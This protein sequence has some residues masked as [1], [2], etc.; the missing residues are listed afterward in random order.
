MSEQPLGAMTDKS[1]Q[2]SIAN[3]VEQ[4]NELEPAW[5][6]QLRKALQSADWPGIKADIIDKTSS[7]AFCD[8]LAMPVAQKLND[9]GFEVHPT[10]VVLP[11]S[12]DIILNDSAHTS[13]IVSRNKDRPYLIDFSYGYYA[14]PRA[15]YQAGTNRHDRP[16]VF[17]PMQ[18]NTIPVQNGQPLYRALYYQD[19][20]GEHIL[21]SPDIKYDEDT[22]D[23][24]FPQMNMLINMAFERYKREVASDELNM[25]GD[26]NTYLSLEYGIDVNDRKNRLY[27]HQAHM[28]TRAVQEAEGFLYGD[29]PHPLYAAR[30]SQ[31]P[32]EKLQSFLTSLDTLM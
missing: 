22:E 19:A 30:W 32:G 4:H 26:F 14:S 7:P 2:P 15:I 12:E 27:P 3:A 10:A 24:D 25:Y 29:D 21:L 9:L 23:A 31:P 16:Y 28:M 6:I 18:D 5:A 20:Q 17:R 1:V 8:V 11:T 13:L